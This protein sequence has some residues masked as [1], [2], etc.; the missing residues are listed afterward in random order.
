M[1]ALP[2]FA[3]T[4]FGCASTGAPQPASSSTAASLVVALPSA[5]PEPRAET[6]PDSPGAGHFWVAGYWDYLGGS[7]IW[8]EGRWVPARANYE[9]VRARHEWNGTSWVLHVPHWKKHRA[10]DPTNVAKR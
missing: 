10:D 1:A 4:M 7:F 6:R 5:P 2:L 8:R 9:Y 3:L